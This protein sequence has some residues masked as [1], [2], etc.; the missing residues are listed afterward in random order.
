MP[1]FSF[2]GGH[3]GDYCRH[4]RGKLA[5]VLEAARARGFTAYGLTEHGPRFQPADLFPDEAGLTPADLAAAFARYLDDAD[6][7]RR[8]TAPGLEVLVG[9]ESEVV[10][11]AT[12]PRL[13][14][15]LR[16]DA[17]IDYVVGS[18]HY[19]EGQCI[20]LSAERTAEVARALGGREALQLAYFDAVTAMVETFRPEIVGH[21]D[22]IRK[23]DGRSPVFSRPVFAAIE[24]A[25]EAT[26]AA[27]AVLDVNAAPAR[28]GFGPVYPLPGI[29]RHARAMGVK[30]TL[31][32][33][34]HGPD[35]VGR[36]L[37]AARAAIADA[38]YRE[39]HHLTRDAGAV[40]W[41]AA[42]LEDV[43]PNDGA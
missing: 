14:G 25:L 5:D 23:F 20:D 19:V 2:H 43:R 31:G 7:L 17:R 30:V 15:D 27:G 40:V 26:R 29:L 8:E 1:W 9:F 34:S 32:D 37:D 33:D 39:V 3:S 22:L 41:R 36:G 11:V 35:D 4:A 38:G 42:K 10:P 16:S 21:I 18:V 12:W 24:R 28:R 13:M 6:G